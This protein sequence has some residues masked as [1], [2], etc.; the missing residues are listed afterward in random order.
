MGKQRAV[1]TSLAHAGVTTAIDHNT[2]LDAF[3]KRQRERCALKARRGVERCRTRQR[4]VA[5]DTTDL[6][7][8]GYTYGGAK[9]GGVSPTDRIERLADAAIKD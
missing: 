2:D 3:F 6:D 1:R 9:G 5:E 7:R 8:R 4:L